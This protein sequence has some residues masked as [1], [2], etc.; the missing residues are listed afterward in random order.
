MRQE[1]RA[2][3]AFLHSTGWTREDALA[4]D[5]LVRDSRTF[6]LETLCISDPLLGAEPEEQTHR[7]FNIVKSSK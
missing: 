7:S 2:R 1:T 6:L 4:G 5:Q 3:C